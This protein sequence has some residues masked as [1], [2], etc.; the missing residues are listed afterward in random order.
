MQLIRYRKDTG[1]IFGIYEA[2]DPALLAAQQRDSGPES[3]WAFLVASVEVPAH[4][5]T[6]W[7][8]RDGQLC[9]REASDVAEEARQHRAYLA[10][11]SLSA[12]SKAVC[13][14]LCAELNTVRDFLDLPA[15]SLADVEAAILASLSPH[16]DEGI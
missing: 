3:P 13:V 9:P 16:P 5:Q 7:T 1:Q 8:I 15:V 4:D 2:N 10:R 6:A 11:R 12:E 14:A